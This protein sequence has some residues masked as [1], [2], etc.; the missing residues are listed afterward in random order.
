MAPI[1]QRIEEIRNERGAAR[2]RYS[3]ALGEALKEFSFEDLTDPLRAAEFY[4]AAY[5]DGWGVHG[6][7]EI[8]RELFLGLYIFDSQT[9]RYGADE[10]LSYLAPRIGI[11]AKVDEAILLATAEKVEAVHRANMELL[12]DEIP[13]I[14]VFDDELGSYEDRRIIFDADASQ[15]LLCGNYNREISRAS[16]L[17]D[18]L[19]IVPTYN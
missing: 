19:R 1:R 9:F 14:S 15:W 7:R 3:E 10:Q 16:E 18:I 6:E 2:D 4:E 12:G 13:R 8:Y 17:I 11:P 5:N